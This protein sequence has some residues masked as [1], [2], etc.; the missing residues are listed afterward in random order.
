[1]PQFVGTSPENPRVPPLVWFNNFSRGDAT[2]RV[3]RDGNALKV[4]HVWVGKRLL[5]AEQNERI[6]PVGR[7]DAQD[8]RAGKKELAAIVG[9][10]GKLILRVVARIQHSALAVA[11]DIEHID[12]AADR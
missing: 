1:M 12:P 4:Q 3:P 8:G 10:V 2:P 6:H 7:T 11:I 5:R 9:I